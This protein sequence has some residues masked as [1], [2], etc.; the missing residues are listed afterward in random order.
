MMNKS[1]LTV[2]VLVACIFG[3]QAFTSA[4]QPRYKNLHILPQDITKDGLDSV[5]QHFTA[6]LGV[7]CSFCHVR[8]EAT[9]RT[10]F[11]SDAKP[12][13]LIARKMMLMSI[14]INKNHFSEIEEEMGHGTPATADTSSVQY[15]LKYVTCYTCHKGDAH[16]VN[17][18]PAREH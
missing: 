2:L 18:P 5:M 10:D 1:F 17:I 16:P 8:D 4:N 3:L 11:S 12:E 14:D 13:K 6:S 15:M 9:K 7:R